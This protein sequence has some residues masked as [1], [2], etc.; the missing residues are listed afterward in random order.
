MRSLNR[1]DIDVV[2]KGDGL[3]ERVSGEKFRKG[4][5]WGMALPKFELWDI[6]LDGG[7][8]GT[9][10]GG[11]VEIQGLVAKI[12]EEK[13]ERISYEWVEAESWVST[14]DEDFTNPG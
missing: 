14:S 6:C 4:T 11:K 10:D 7:I 9:D 1:E 5:I 3:L 2:I 12:V 13:R 8:L